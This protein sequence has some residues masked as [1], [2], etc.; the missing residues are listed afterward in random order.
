M[1]FCERG[2]LYD[3]LK[4]DTVKM[5]WWMAFTMLEEV[6]KGIKCLHDHDPVIMHRD[7]KVNISLRPF[8]TVFIDLIVQTLNVLVT[9]NYHC[10]L[11]DFGLA[12]MDTSSNL[13]MLAPSRG[14]MH[15]TSQLPGTLQNCR[16]TYAYIAPEIYN[17]EKYT[18]MATC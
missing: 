8:A 15:C 4:D 11:C 6:V 2:S 18:G 12:R 3:V 16:G 1:E 13:G 17:G 7:L 9:E 5:D 14:N 10:K